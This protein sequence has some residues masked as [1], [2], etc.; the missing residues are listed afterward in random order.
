M[1][2]KFL[3]PVIPGPTPIHRLSG[4]TKVQMFVV[5]L[6]LSLMSFDLRILIPLFILASIALISLRPN[7][8]IIAV[9]ASIIVLMNI[10]NMFLYWI[11]NPAVGEYWNGGT[12]T[13][14]FSFTSHY[15][16]SLETLWYLLVRFIKMIISFMI[17]MVFIQAITP[18]ELAAGLHS[19]KIPYKVCT[20]V[21][22]AFRYIPDIGRDYDN[23]KISL[24][25]R[26]VELDRRRTG[27][28]KRLKQMA[29]ILFPLI[30]TAFDRIGNIANGMDL[31]GYGLRK[32]RTYYAEHPLTTSDKIVRWTTLLLLIFCIFWI[33]SRMIWPP[34]TRMWFP[35]RV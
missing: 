22:L 29:L 27:L 21:S 13:I 10:L 19:M 7:W 25:A 23:I 3:I 15:F 17:S 35:F 4:T 30:I 12:R 33:V 6:V 18:S 14:L 24:Q 26:G 32:D 31:R 34:A 9:L 11:A 5:L 28:F 8:K 20:V 2:N 16:V 1:T